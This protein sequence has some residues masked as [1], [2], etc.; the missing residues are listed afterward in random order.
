MSFGGG[1]G[2]DFLEGRLPVFVFPT[3]L[4]FYSDDPQSQTRVITIY[5]PYDFPLSYK[6]LST[7]PAKYSVTE[8]E[9]VIK[10]RC[11]TDV[12]IRHVD[13]SIKNEGIREKFR[14][15]LC[16]YR[17][18]KILGRRDVAAILLPTQD[19]SKSET[20][21]SFEE[22]F[23][24][25]SSASGHASAAASPS[26]LVKLQNQNSSS[27]SLPVGVVLT[28]LTCLLALMLPSVGDVPPDL[29]ELPNY[30]YLTLH[31]KLLAAYVL[32]MVTVIVFRR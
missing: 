24:G 13:I 7:D 2:S 4:V 30:L 32:G 11:G 22:F 16:E 17:K 9:G 27:I 8:P 15:Q 3:S 23:D 31:Q 21:K 25:A 29:F 5:N 28:A 10:S 18:K 26:T 6:V 1:T 19:K 20:E 12:L 14:V